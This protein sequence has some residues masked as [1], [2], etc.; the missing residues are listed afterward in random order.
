MIARLHF[1]GGAR[2][3]P[4]PGGSEWVLSV[5]DINTQ[6]WNLRECG[7]SYQEPHETNNTCEF[8]ALQAGLKHAVRAFGNT[9]TRVEVVG[10]SNMII[11]TQR[12][13]AKMK[14]AHLTTTETKVDRLAGELAWVSWTHAN[15]DF[16]KMADSLA[17][18][19]MGTKRTVTLTRASGGVDQARF[20][21]VEQLLSNDLKPNETIWRTTSYLQVLN[22]YRILKPTG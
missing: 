19:A 16:N 5:Q 14:A 22:L 1:D 8:K 12:G 15:R 6:K 11:D 7:F 9:A 10:D 13:Y 3:N 17:N 21:Q 2:G 20:S 18:L 4:G